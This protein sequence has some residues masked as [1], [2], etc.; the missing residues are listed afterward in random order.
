LAEAY[1]P[2]PMSS[3][4]QRINSG[5]SVTSMALHGAG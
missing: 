2:E 1:R 5:L 4:I 3:S